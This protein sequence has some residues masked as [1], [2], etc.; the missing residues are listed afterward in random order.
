[1][2]ILHTADWHLGK[3]LEQNDRLAEQAAFLDEL[4]EI[5]RAETVDLLL[6]AGDVFDTY[7]PPAAAEKLFYDALE[8]LADH[9]RRAV[10][11]I[12]G[13][14]DNPDRLSAAAPLAYRHGIYLLGRPTA[15]AGGLCRQQDGGPD[16]L[17][18]AGPGF[19]RLRP[20]GADHAVTL[21]TLPYP[22]ESRLADLANAMAAAPADE[23]SLQQDYSTRIGQLFETLAA[24]H[25]SDTTVNIA[26]SHLFMQGGWS[27]DSERTLQLGSAMLVDPSCLPA[28]AQYVALGHLHRPQAVSG[29]PVPARYAGS[30]LAYSFSE[31]DYTKS[32]CLV[33]V[34]PGQP[35]QVSTIP[36][37]SGRPL[38]R[39]QAREGI[40]QAL[41]WA[42]DGRDANCWIDVE[43]T[44]DRLPT[45]AEMKALREFNPGILYVRSRLTGTAEAASAPSDRMAR[46]IEDLFAEYYLFRNGVK[47]PPDVLADFIWLAAEETEADT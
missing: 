33:Q 36:L 31:A 40:A 34:Q 38:R 12:A 29:S 43:V 27:S 11:V 16:I 7:N 20:S 46:R 25:F 37:R 44:T 10:V 18:A 14:H 47:I 4:S 24:R 23:A 8:R 32:V 28:A 35:A 41:S 3:S 22:S 2:K 6:V 17:E 13:N 15:D 39:W 19:L 26:I 30:P 9:G 45:A 5:C 1:M 21:L 42:E